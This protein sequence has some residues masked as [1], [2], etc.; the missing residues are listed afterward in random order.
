M[1]VLLFTDFIETWQM[2]LS[3]PTAGH[4]L[5]PSW[6][7]P[8]E[9][10]MHAAVTLLPVRQITLAVWYAL[11][12]LLMPLVLARRTLTGT[13]ENDSYIRL[14]CLGCIFFWT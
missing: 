11:L 10:P 8:V 6:P 9:N 3:V 12:P 7:E 1:I 2:A 14:Y 13:N 4:G 5:L